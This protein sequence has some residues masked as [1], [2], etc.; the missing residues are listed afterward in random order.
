MPVTLIRQCPVAKKG[1][2]KSDQ[3]YTLSADGLLMRA[4][5]DRAQPDLQYFTRSRK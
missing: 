5:K 2:R 4:K 3:A 1:L